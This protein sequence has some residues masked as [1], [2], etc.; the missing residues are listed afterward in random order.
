VRP[1]IRGGPSVYQTS[2]DALC[3]LLRKVLVDGAQAG[4]GATGGVGSVEWQAV[5]TLYSL[6]RD[7]PV[8]QWGRCRSCRRPGSVF[9]SRWRP[10]RVHSKATL[11]LRQLDDVLLLDLLADE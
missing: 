4:R 2:R 1:V 3:Q 11:C 6:L 7:H 5:I 9:G 8:D 10:C